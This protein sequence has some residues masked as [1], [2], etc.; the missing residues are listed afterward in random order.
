MLISG[1]WSLVSCLLDLNTYS[2]NIIQQLWYSYFLHTCVVPVHTQMYP[3][4]TPVHLKV[5]FANMITA[6]NNNNNTNISF[7]HLCN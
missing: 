2:S 4:S 7:I 3:G 5:L 6:T 1:L